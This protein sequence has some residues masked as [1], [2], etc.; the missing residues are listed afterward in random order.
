MRRARGAARA[1]DRGARGGA[2]YPG[3]MRTP[4]APVAATVA[5]LVAALFAL[6]ACGGAPTDV[7]PEHREAAAHRAAAAAQRLGGALLTELTS[8]LDTG[9]PEE[10]VHV[11]ADVAQRISV[12]IAAAEGVAVGRTALRVRNPANAP[13]DWERKVLSEWAT[14][15]G[16]DGPSSAVVD[17]PD[18]PALRWMSPIRLVGLCTQCHGDDTQISTATRAA[19]ADR[20]PD[21]QAT[22]FAVG[23]I[24]GAFTVT[25]PLRP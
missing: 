17:T 9:P 21:D 16:G 11:C 18:G 23:D 14:G 22:D 10:A 13:D 6:A 25:V 24:R 7:T 8:A 15:M 19:I 1:G 12:D 2:R 20:Y 4:T 3:T 5:A